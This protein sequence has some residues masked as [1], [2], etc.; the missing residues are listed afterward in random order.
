MALEKTC[1]VSLIPGN[2]DIKH[3]EQKQSVHV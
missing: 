3:G 1:V 2:G